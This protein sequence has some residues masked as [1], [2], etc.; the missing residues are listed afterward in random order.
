LDDKSETNEDGGTRTSGP[1]LNWKWTST[2][3]IKELEKYETLSCP[4][5]SLPVGSSEKYFFNYL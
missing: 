1:N 3:N 4:K 2:L 5:H